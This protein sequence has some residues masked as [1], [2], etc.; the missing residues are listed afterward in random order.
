MNVNILIELPTSF[1]TFTP[2]R[3]VLHIDIHFA[4]IV[5]IDQLFR[6][7]QNIKPKLGSDTISLIT[8][9]LKTSRILTSYTN[10]INIHYGINQLT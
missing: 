9:S 1:V 10:I 2:T 4:V 7:A 6:S 3:T 5:V 8:F